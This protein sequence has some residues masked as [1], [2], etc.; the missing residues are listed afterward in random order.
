VFSLRSSP[1]AAGVNTK[2]A[3]AEAF[4]LFQKAALQ[5]QTGARIKLGYM[6]DEGRGTQRDRQTAYAWISAASLAG[7]PRGNDLLHSLQKVLSPEQIVRAQEQ[8]GRLRSEHPPQ[9]SANAFA[10]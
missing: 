10:P 8:A 3:D 4:R 1:P 7:D 6:Y 2:A 5:G 9:L